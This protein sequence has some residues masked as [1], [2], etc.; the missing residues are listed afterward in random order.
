MR[1]EQESGPLYRPT[2]RERMLYLSARAMALM[3]DAVKIRLSREAPIV[4]DGQHLD[5]QL[6][7]IRSVARGRQLPGLIEP[8]VAAGRQRYRRQTDVFRGPA[9]HVAAVRDLEIPTRSGALLR[10]R[11]YQPHATD[12]DARE[13]ITVYFHGGGFVIGDL[14][15]HDEPCRLLCR[16]ASVH[17]LSVAYRLAPEHPFPAA[18]DDAA[19]AVAWARTNAASLGAD[20]DR[21]AAGGDSAGANLTAVVGAEIGGPRPFAQLLMYPATDFNS[22]RPSQHV[23]A[24][25]FYLSRRDLDGFRDAYLG[26][27]GVPFDDPRVSPLRARNLAG[28]PPTLLVIAGFD[29]LRDD[30]EAYG[31][32]LTEAGARVR[33][34]RFPSLGHG[35]IHMTGVAPAARRAVTAIAGA[36]R[37]MLG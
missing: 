11:H 35:F 15:T 9:T 36:W 22:V 13:P 19:S 29:P 2:A 5:P 4:V 23:F 28:V 8:T 10:A 1:A 37:A 16:H 20:P 7:V 21:V 14:D 34:L 30:G 32:A 12:R 18:L 17:V 26:G 3:P 25:G 24:N 27:T 6:Q 33:T 31:R